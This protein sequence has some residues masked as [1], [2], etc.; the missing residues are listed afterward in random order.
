GVPL[1]LL[2]SARGGNVATQQWIDDRVFAVTAIHADFYDPA[3]PLPPHA[4]VVNAIGDADRCG[5]ALDC[6]EAML[7]GTSA[8]VINPPARVRATSRE[9][10]ALRL[11]GIAGVIAPKTVRLPRAAMSAAGD[12]GYPLL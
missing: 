8:P 7:A 6:A 9:A 11:G 12:L 10:H 2:V 5:H 3:Q 4:L 1:L